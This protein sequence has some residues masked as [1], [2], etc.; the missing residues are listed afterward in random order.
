MWRYR[1][2]DSPEKGKTVH[3]REQP[4]FSRAH[5]SPPHICHLPGPLLHLPAQIFIHL[6]SASKQALVIEPLEPSCPKA[7]P[8]E[9]A[10]FEI[11]WSIF[12]PHPFAGLADG[13]FMIDD[14]LLEPPPF[15]CT[16]NRCFIRKWEL[17]PVVTRLPAV[18]QGWGFWAVSFIST[19]V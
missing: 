16:E 6:P 7:G 3:E 13:I 14:D 5:E 9:G 10:S 11:G 2:Y 17:V 19:I 18:L 15:P 4:G 1:G 12:E 8:L